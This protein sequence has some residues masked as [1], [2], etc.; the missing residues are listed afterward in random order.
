MHKTEKSTLG[1]LMGIIIGVMGLA[2]AWPAPPVQAQIER[3]QLLAIAS[4]LDVLHDRLDYK[5][6]LLNTFN[7]GSDF[8]C[9]TPENIF[10]G[11]GELVVT[12]EFYL[13]AATSEGRAK[14]ERLLQTF[15]QLDSAAEFYTKALWKS[16]R[17]HALA[18][19][20]ADLDMQYKVALDQ[21]DEL[22]N[23]VLK[24]LSS[25]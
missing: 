22:R 5:R 1:I 6:S 24:K 12:L 18:L 14:I 2:L 11:S 15:K 19:A 21:I 16:C 13:F 23:H 10:S 25:E 20:W 3:A 17:P 8:S 4:G 7:K 9:I